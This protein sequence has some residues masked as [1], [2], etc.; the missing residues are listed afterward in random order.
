MSISLKGYIMLNLK[1]EI[2]KKIKSCRIYKINSC[3]SNVLDKIAANLK[4]NKNIIQL[5]QGNISSNNFLSLCKSLRQLT[6]IYDSLLIIKDRIDIA[7][8]IDA[9][10]IFLTKDTVDYNSALKIANKNKI[11]G[12]DITYAQY[13]DYIVSDNVY[14]GKI[15][16]ILNSNTSEYKAYKEVIYDNDI[17]N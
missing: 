6:S 13:S 4:Y 2:L 16:Y 1:N 14:N 3:N 9:D 8:I 17:S 12:S 5:E 11:I 15:T 10:G 7:C